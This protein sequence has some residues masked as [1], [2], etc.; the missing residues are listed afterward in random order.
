MFWPASFV[1]KTGWDGDD[2]VHSEYGRREMDSTEI[3]LECNTA[4]STRGR[5]L[6]MIVMDLERGDA[7]KWSL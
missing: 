4:P 2:S 1:A 5:R 3:K 7:I 6:I